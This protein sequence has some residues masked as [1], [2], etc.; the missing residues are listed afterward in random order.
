[1]TKGVTKRQNKAKTSKT[2]NIK[3]VVQNDKP[4]IVTSEVTISIEKI[5]NNDFED[6][7]I[8]TPITAS[9]QKDNR[10]MIS[11]MSVKQVLDMITN[12]FVEYGKHLYSKYNQEN[13]TVQY[14]KLMEKSYLRNV[15]FI[16]N[17][18]WVDMNQMDSFSY[19]DYRNIDDMN[20]LFYMISEEKRNS[21]LF[22][23]V[24]TF[25]DEL[26]D[27]IVME[28]FN[29]LLNGLYHDEF[30]TNQDRNYYYFTYYMDMLKCILDKNSK[31]YTENIFHIGSLLQINNGVS[32]LYQPY[33]NVENCVATKNLVMAI[34]SLT[35]MKRTNISRAMSSIGLDDSDIK[36][37]INFVLTPFLGVFYALRRLDME[38]DLLLIESN[39]YNKQ[40]VSKPHSSWI[41]EDD[42]DEEAYRKEREEVMK[43][44]RAKLALEEE[45]RKR[46]I[47][48]IPVYD[49]PRGPP[50]VLQKKFAQKIDEE[51][52]A[53]AAAASVKFSPTASVNSRASAFVTE[54][55]SVINSPTSTVV[56]DNT[57]KHTYVPHDFVFEENKIPKSIRRNEKNETVGRDT[58]FLIFHAGSASDHVYERAAI[59][60][61][62][63]RFKCA[64]KDL[65]SELPRLLVEK[66]KFLRKS[67]D[68]VFGKSFEELFTNDVKQRKLYYTNL[69]R[70][71]I[72]FCNEIAATHR[73]D[74]DGRMAIVEKYYGPL[75][76]GETE[77][78]YI[79]SFMTDVFRPFINFYNYA[80]TL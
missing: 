46:V 57:N 16:L 47:D 78:M 22:Q 32:S 35:T 43:L 37:Y 21:W 40:C 13:D 23:S 80:K 7:T 50:P 48:N 63:G 19:P 69:R 28:A 27:E 59:A 61:H 8:S 49:I 5:T 2:T 30:M 76:S 68:K 74:N 72:S 34:H 42:F 51:R 60:T 75:K 52:A 18:T 29:A 39:I 66:E 56:S 33:T 4:T 38:N 45:Q 36:M 31:N 77:K 12:S 58:G 79:D 62:G 6:R 1:M 65:C 15:R 41:D 11:F 9:L 70:A 67:R 71:I 20:S 14:E 55:A 54:N 26:S 73:L 3:N 64:I 44:H 25:E 24:Q 10:K 53:A 17:P